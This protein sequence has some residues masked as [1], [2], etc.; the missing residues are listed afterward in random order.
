MI[1]QLWLPPRGVG[2]PA[3]GVLVAAALLLPCWTDPY[4]TATASRILALGLLSASVTLIT[5][6]AGLPT[7]GQTAPFAVG[8]YTAAVLAHHGHTLGPAQIAAA[9]TAATGFAAVSGLLLV[10]TRGSIHLMISIGVGQLTLTAADHWTAVTG[11]S[12]GLPFL[13]GTRPLPGLPALDSDRAVYL[14]TA[15]VALAAL[16]IIGWVLRRPGAMLL[17]GVRDNEARMAASGHPT[18]RYLYTAHLAAGALAG[19]GGALLV[20][21]QHTITPGD[22]DFT[23][24]S[25]ALLACTLG[26]R[27]RLTGAVTGTAVILTVRDVIGGPFAGHAPL[28]LGALYITCVYNLHWAQPRRRVTTNHPAAADPTV[29]NTSSDPGPAHDAAVPC[30]RAGT[31][32]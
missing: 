18:G 14:Y 25:L 32:P 1:R 17:R 27:T 30:L 6:H 8:G 22:G 13:P 19:V 2:R 31:S 21:A 4:T 5:G 16:T 20:T 11:G 9:A 26:G 10:H 15:A 28:L 12:D 23:T 7:L 24:A 29:A 3:A